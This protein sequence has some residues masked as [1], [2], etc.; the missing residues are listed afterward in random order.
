[1][2]LLLFFG[3]AIGAGVAS[4]LVHR[5]RV[6]SAGIGIGG[7]VVAFL[8]ATRIG[9]D[10]AIR[11]GGVELAESDY[12]RLF[13][14]FGSLAGF[15]SVLVA[16]ATSWSVA[17]PG[18][19]LVV[20][21]GNGLAL[22]LADS[23]SATAAATIGSL[24]GVIVTLGP[25]AT[26]AGLGVARRE[27]RALVAASILGL[28]AA[29]IASSQSAIGLDPAIVGLAFVSF[30]G[31]AAI[32][33]GSIPFHL[34]VARAADT[35]P[36]LGLSLVMAWAP[37]GFVAVVLAWL[38]A[39]I[40]PLGESFATERALIVL[41]AAM[42]IVLGSVAATLHADLEHVVGY[43]IVADGA[44]ALLGLAVL[45]PAAW[46]PTRTWILTFALAKSAFAAWVAAVHFTYGARQVGELDGWARRSPLLGL[47][48]LGVVIASVGLPGMA[49]LE[50]RVEL[51]RL[52]LP[53]PLAIGLLVLSVVSLGYYVRLAV[54]GFRRPSVAVSAGADPMLRLTRP[55]REA[56]TTSR[57]AG[58]ART[59]RGRGNQLAEAMTVLRANRAPI[60]AALVL[61]MC[62]VAVILSAA[63][64]GLEG[65][66]AA[67]RPEPALPLGFTPAGASL[68]PAP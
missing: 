63:A 38:N 37:A 25:V 40:A 16:L 8:V 31:A 54:I 14:V 49:V 27:L 46:G 32:R 13:L 51:A 34:W 33:L 53:E 66:A 45:D 61:A 18:A 10:E 11:V 48:L 50:T 64:F 57:R 12:T 44:I 47:G 67:A 60:A 30:V 28:A 35:T 5:E 20:L 7:L 23:P 42:T 58:A 15:L 41:V 43:S 1:V 52:A 6:L 17:L 68:S 62:G 39:S 59:V 26:S 24:A 56:A 3:V 36:P 22:A 65:A 21:A 4:L 2:N 29:G 55:R 9:A 19:W